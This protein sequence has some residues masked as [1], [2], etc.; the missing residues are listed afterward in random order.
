MNKGQTQTADVLLLMMM[1]MILSM[2]P[3]PED[4]P[5]PTD[6]WL[7]TNELLASLLRNGDSINRSGTPL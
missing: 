5:H 6:S 2:L 1:R 4:I 3:K 7:K